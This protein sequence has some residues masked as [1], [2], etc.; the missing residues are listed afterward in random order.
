M[1]NFLLKSDY[2]NNKGFLEKIALG[3]IFEFLSS[4]EDK[5]NKDYAEFKSSEIDKFLDAYTAE[6]KTSK[7]LVE[8]ALNKYSTWYRTQKMLPDIFEEDLEGIENKVD[9]LI[10][11]NDLNNTEDREIKKGEEK[12]DIRL[13]GRKTEFNPDRYIS[14]EE[15][16]EYCEKLESPFDKLLIRSIYEGFDFTEDINDI[17]NLK[18][19]DC[20]TDNNIVFFSS[21]KQLKVS[22]KLMELLIK[23]GNN[24]ENNNYCF[25]FLMRE[26]DPDRKELKMSITEK[27]QIQRIKKELE[28]LKITNSNLY[29]S[30]YLNSLQETGLMSGW[31]YLRNID[32]P[33]RN[34][35]LKLYKLDDKRYDNYQRKIKTYLK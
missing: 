23:C 7:K 22:D 12:T 25:G 33:E 1:K 34:E 19:E 11:I 3:N 2:V 26:R 30:G 8:E 18:L 6:T 24:I 21:G 29:Y 10:G 35:I 15:L 4:Y 32:T 16:N 13:K 5:A 31:E 17:A 27:N 28:C 20:D 9:N 14:K